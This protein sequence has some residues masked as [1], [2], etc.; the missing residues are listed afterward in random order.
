M[1][2][3]R[4]IPDDAVYAGYRWGIIKQDFGKRQI[5]QLFFRTWEDHRGQE[6]TVRK[7]QAMLVCPLVEF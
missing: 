3:G 4:D 6:Q 7:E 5:D 2:R 1:D